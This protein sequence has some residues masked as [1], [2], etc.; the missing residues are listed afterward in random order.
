V[1]NTEKTTDYWICNG[2]SGSPCQNA[3]H[4]GE[5]IKHGRECKT[6]RAWSKSAEP[7]AFCKALVPDHLGGRIN[8]FA[9]GAKVEYLSGGRIKDGLFSPNPK[10]RVC[11]ACAEKKMPGINPRSENPGMILVE[12]GLEPAFLPVQMMPTPTTIIDRIVQRGR[13][14]P[15]EFS[16]KKPNHGTILTECTVHRV[17]PSLCSS[18]NGEAVI[19]EMRAVRVNKR[20]LVLICAPCAVRLLQDGTIEL[21]PGSGAEEMSRLLGQPIGSGRLD[22]IL[23]MPTTKVVGHGAGR[24]YD[25]VRAQM[26]FVL[27]ANGVGER[28]RGCVGKK[29]REP[30]PKAP[31]GLKIPSGRCKKCAATQKPCRKCKERAAGRKST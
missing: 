20:S 28:K 25:P 17:C 3:L 27:I 19:E 8:P 7:C 30:R 29:F 23:P 2:E 14:L 9:L 31:A 15:E 22:N 13:V 12:G 10:A 21:L 11:D 4:E 16:R 5:R 6:G 1:G 18:Q 26:S 24:P